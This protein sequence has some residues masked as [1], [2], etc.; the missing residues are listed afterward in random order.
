M[1]RTTLANHDRFLHVGAKQH[2]ID[3]RRQVTGSDETPSIGISVSSRPL[4]WI[5]LFSKL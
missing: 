3:G 1:G 5:P 4:P 2:S